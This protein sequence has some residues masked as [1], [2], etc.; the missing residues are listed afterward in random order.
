MKSICIFL[1]LLCGYRT[2]SA[3]FV[4]ESDDSLKRLAESVKEN[5][6]TQY[7]EIQKM[8]PFE[9]KSKITVRIAGSMKEYEALQPE[10]YR[11]PTWSVG[12]AYPSKRLVV[13]RGD[14]T[15]GPD[16]ILRTFR[17]ELAHVFLHNYSGMKIPKWF[18]E[19]FS[20]YFE[21]RGGL[22]RS[23]RL[24][25]Q[26]FSNSYIDIDTL[27]DTF[28]DNPVDIQNA[29]LTSAEFFSFM[30][31]KIGEEGLYRV[32]EN[33]G[34]GLDFRYSIYKVAGKTVSDMEKEYK[35][36]SRFR[37][38]W[39]PVITSSTTLW[40]LLTFLFIYVFV[41]KKR[42]TG[43]KLEIMKMEEELILLD[44]F[45]KESKNEDD[46]DRTVN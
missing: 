40:L 20:M 13:L 10:G 37:Y 46:S 17:H 14:A 18:S 6:E 7:S 44:R 43:K 21:D 32:F 31:S 41:V 5:A 1:L 11:A 3:N 39:L 23:F 38:A 9:Q 25:K 42:R 8:M 45:E 16:E 27:E 30:L 19:G 22:G 34:R 33:V 24:M 4:I 36:S 26:A 15:H 2:E 28:P 29:Y 12:I 35:K